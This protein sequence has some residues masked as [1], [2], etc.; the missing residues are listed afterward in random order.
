[1]ILQIVG[2]K[3]SG[4]T[5]LM[6]HAVKSLKAAGHSVVTVKHHGHIGEEIVLPER[7][8]DHMRHF[9]A[10]ADQS[11]VQGHDYVES[12]ERNRYSTLEDLLAECVTIAHSVI[13]VEGYK[14]ALYPKVIVYRDEA[15]LLALQQ[16]YN[17]QY[18]IQRTIDG[19]D[20]KQ[21]D[22]W[23]TQWIKES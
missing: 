13:L 1:M 6:T 3:N 5:T 4:K 12:I 21:F 20:Y 9:E 16:L 19:F 22:A 11:I 23:L 7:Q 8:V 15:E 17:V 14:E 2:Y 18:A 10:G